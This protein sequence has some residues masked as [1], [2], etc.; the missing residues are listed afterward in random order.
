[1]CTAN[2][3]CVHNTSRLKLARCK[4]R[5][6]DENQEMA[7]DKKWDSRQLRYEC[8]SDFN[9]RKRVNT[10]FIKLQTRC[11]S[12]IFYQIFRICSGN[13]RGCL[14]LT[15]KTLTWINVLQRI[16]L[17]H[18]R[19]QVKKNISVEGEAWKICS[20]PS[21]Y[22]QKKECQY[23]TLGKVGLIHRWHS[24]QTTDCSWSLSTWI[25]SNI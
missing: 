1:M 11:T 7:E 18:F 2:K 20:L 15:E 23:W 8:Y 13:F 16:N 5:E 21:P 14:L 4:H 19:K 22:S 25:P 3:P 10:E 24:I 6:R 17:T 12:H 9:L